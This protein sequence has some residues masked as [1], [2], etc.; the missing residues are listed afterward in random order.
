M[1]W[2]S[3]V[4]KEFVDGLERRDDIVLYFKLPAFFTVPT[5]IGNYNPDWAI[6]KEDRDA[7]GE[8]T[9]K[10]KLYLV[11]ETKGTTESDKLRHNEERKI[12]CGRRHFCET[13]NV[14]YEVVIPFLF[15]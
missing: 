5:P 6:V 4:E 9:G 12:D 1:I 3:E 7:H 13:L 10:E 11:R 15:K 8:P 2:D 14:D